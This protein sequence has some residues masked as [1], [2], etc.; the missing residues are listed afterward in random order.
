MTPQLPPVDIVIANYNYVAYVGDAIASALTQ[1]HPGVRVVVV[2]DGSTDGSLEVIGRFAPRVRIHARENGGQG[3]AIN[4]GF[5][6]GDGAVVIFLDA[7]DVLDPS[8]ARRVAETFGVDPSL[9]RVQY[10]LR[11]ID[12]AARPTGEVKPPLGTAMPAGDLRPYLI[13]GSLDLPWL[14]MSGNAFARRALD[15]LMP[16]PERDYRILADSYLVHLAPV[17]GPVAFLEEVLGSYRVHGANSHERAGLDLE[18]VR[19]TIVV[20]QTTIRDL[21]DAASARGAS[22]RG[23]REEAVSD[24][25][26]RLISLRLDPT[27]HPRKGD[28]R[29]GLAHAGVRCSLSRRDIGFPRRVGLATWFGVMWAAPRPIARAAATA[30]LDPAR[31]NA[32]ASRMRRP[33]TS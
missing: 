16:M 10:R 1:D 29:V 28:R 23:P 22:P 15:G 14:P 19:R 33:W 4:D 8:A 25:A 5:A 21:R 20:A 26:H 3:A 30:L 27:R 31:R 24:L 13:A 9:S 2:D 6:V 12:A 7:D 32:V 11:V 17:A 18:H